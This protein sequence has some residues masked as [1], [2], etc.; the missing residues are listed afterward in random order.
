MDIFEKLT[1]AGFI[2]LGFAPWESGKGLQI[3]N[4]HELH[5]EAPG[6]YVMHYE[7][8]IHKV[9]KSSASLKRRLLGY[10]KFDRDRLAH[11]ETGSDRSSRKQRSA[12]ERLA[13]PGFHVLAL[14]ADICERNLPGLGFPVKISSFD[15]HDLERKVI[16]LVKADDHKL[17]FGA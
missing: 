7:G 13:V 8:R 9:G 17:E 2:D 5:D 10:S 12:I 11:A 6:V 3:Q 1:G 4:L 16:K 15:A 14:Q